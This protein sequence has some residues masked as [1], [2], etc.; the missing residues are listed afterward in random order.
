MSRDL[1]CRVR[2]KI[3][4]ICMTLDLRFAVEAKF[5]PSIQKFLEKEFLI[6]KRLCM[7]DDPPNMVNQFTILKMFV[8]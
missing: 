5:C 4:K 6:S 7:N 8:V 1:K 2:N 3:L